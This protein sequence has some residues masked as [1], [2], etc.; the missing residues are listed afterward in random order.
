MG[1][2]SIVFL[3]LLIL[4][5]S[6]SVASAADDLSV[7]TDISSSVDTV[8]IDDEL[9][10]SA[11]IGL[12]TTIGGSAEDDSSISMES[13]DSLTEGDDLSED[14]NTI[15]DISTDAS[16]SIV[17][18]GAESEISDT[19]P[20]ATYMNVVRDDNFYGSQ[21]LYYYFIGDTCELRYD[22]NAIHS[23]GHRRIVGN[24]DVYLNGEFITTVT[25]N[26]NWHGYI[27]MTGFNPGNNTVLFVFNGTEEYAPS[28]ESIIVKGFSKRTSVSYSLI[29][30]KYPILG[31]DLILNV[32]LKSGG[33]ILNEDFILKIDYYKDGSP[34]TNYTGKGGT[35]VFPTD[36]FTKA[37]YSV[38]VIYPGS[39]D[40]I[41]SPVYDYVDAF[42]MNAEKEKLSILVGHYDDVVYENSTKFSFR[43]SDAGGN[44]E[45]ELIDVYINGEFYTTVLTSTKDNVVVTIENLRWGNNTIKLVLNETYYMKGVNKTFKTCYSKKNTET[46]ISAAK[47]EI[48]IYEELNM[49]LNVKS[50]AG[51]IHESVK[52]GYVDIYINGVKD[53]TVPLRSGEFIFKKDTPGEYNISAIYVGNEYLEGSESENIT[54]TVKY[55]QLT[56]NLHL[57][58]FG[59]SGNYIDGVYYDLIINPGDSAGL[60]TELKY[61]DLHLNYDVDIYVNGTL[62]NSTLSWQRYYHNLPYVGLYNFTAKFNGAEQYTATGFSESRLVYVKPISTYFEIDSD[63]QR[64]KIGEA[65]TLNYNL[66]TENGMTE[67]LMGTVVLYY[68]SNNNK[69]LETSDLSGSVT[70]IARKIGQETIRFEFLSSSEYYNDSHTG[71]FNF[72]VDAKMDNRA[73]VSIM[74]DLVDSDVDGNRISISYMLANESSLDGYTINDLIQGGNIKWY[75]DNNYCAFTKLNSSEGVETFIVDKEGLH[76]ITAVFDEDLNMLNATC[77]LSHFFKQSTYV[78]VSCDSY[79]AYGETYDI[80]FNAHYDE[81]LLD[82]GNVEVY[83][84]GV[85]NDTI[86]ISK[87][88]IFRFTPT[89]FGNHNITFKYLENDFYKSSNKTVKFKVEKSFPGLEISIE[90]TVFYVNETAKFKILL[91]SVIEAGSKLIEVYVSK[92][93]AADVLNATIDLSQSDVF[94]FAPKKAGSYTVRFVFNEDDYSFH[95]EDFAD[96]V[97]KPLPVATKIVCSNMTTTA[98]DTKVDGKK[99]QYLSITL[100]DKNNKVLAGKTVEITLNK[101]TYKVKTNSNGIAKLQINIK[102]AG[103]YTASIKF[104]GDSPYIK[105]S[106]SIKIKV[107]KQKPKISAAKKT[108]KRTAKTKKVTAKLTTSRGKILKNKK[109]TFTV[110]GKKYTVKTNSKGIA[111]AKVKLTK[112]GTFTC[113]IKYAGDTTYKAITKSIKVVVK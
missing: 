101:V 24:M 110:N 33:E 25:S 30:P 74:L 54:I 72:I 64:P 80:I 106:A 84:D 49:G 57:Y 3:L 68:D 78:D 70:L 9:Q 56:P 16:K 93:G 48:G 35:I 58:V 79:L 19:E 27:N 75:L 43:V 82:S 92:D 66:T 7:D 1:K 77:T 99:G 46:Y 88:N 14:S 45:S 95:V 89:A 69:I 4:T 83:V 94:Q 112:K 73:P 41:Y 65:M 32:N 44:M 13:G 26:E 47:S 87:S 102:K 97:F 8:S 17:G 100:K 104:A 71:N 23:D 15:T 42:Y 20:K 28:N 67:G 76:N 63:I 108:F 50:I 96:L 2:E 5:L 98:I 85:L 59:D 40:D 51:P 103:T 53:T 6:I 109:L 37:E 55:I 34:M 60:S 10:D 39:S 21:G 52:E 61:N 29:E 113:K 12:E 62:V 81:D 11:D 36:N 91:T 111:T 107:N 18:Q 90:K 31:H 38:L 22:L 86:D 105:S